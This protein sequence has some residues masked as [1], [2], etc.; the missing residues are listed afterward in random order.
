MFA[1][2]SFERGLR[3]ALSVP[4]AAVVERGQL[5]GVFV[6]DPDGLARLRWI[7]LGRVRGER[8]EVLSGLSEGESYLSAP[9]PGLADGTPVREG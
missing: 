8:V 2:A 4:L 9:P 3:E 6:L 1:R 7:R 5:Q